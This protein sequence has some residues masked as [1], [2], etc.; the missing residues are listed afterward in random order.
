MQSLH[1]LG[2]TKKLC[3]RVRA[4]RRMCSGQSDHM[5]PKDRRTRAVESTQKWLAR[6]QRKGT[7]S[8]RRIV[9]RGGVKVN[10]ARAFLK[11]PTPCLRR[12]ASLEQ[13]DGVPYSPE[14]TDT[15][16]T[17]R[18]L[19]SC[20]RSDGSVRIGRRSR[21]HGRTLDGSVDRPLAFWCDGTNPSTRSATPTCPSGHQ[22]RRFLRF[23]LPHTPPRTK[24]RRSESTPSNRPAPP[25]RRAHTVAWRPGRGKANPPYSKRFSSVEIDRSAVDSDRSDA[26]RGSWPCWTWDDPAPRM[27]PGHCGQRVGKARTRARAHGRACWN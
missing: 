8:T 14:R 27:R 23:L 1:R 6:F 17:R 24:G 2:C 18:P 3:H 22:G 13:Q 25:Q 5:G 7:R 21:G 4:K 10:L 12:R 15:F 20:D 19:L 16:V 26:F 11:L 9:Q